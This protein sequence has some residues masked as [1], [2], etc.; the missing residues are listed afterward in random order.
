[1][2]GV[3]SLIA[4]LFEIDNLCAASIL[5]SMETPVDDTALKYNLNYHWVMSFH[6]WSPGSGEQLHL[7]DRHYEHLYIEN[8]PVAT[9]GCK[10]VA[11]LSAL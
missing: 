10:T 8:R 9:V 1:M 2:F 7:T 5:A 11:K 6:G 4:Y 3:R